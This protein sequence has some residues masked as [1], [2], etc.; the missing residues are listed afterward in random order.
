MNRSSTSPLP[1]SISDMLSNLSWFIDVSIV[2]P[3]ILRFPT[4]HKVTHVAAGR[5]FNEKDNHYTR[6]YDMATSGPRSLAPCILEATGSL[7]KFFEHAASAAVG[8]AGSQGCDVGWIAGIVYVPSG[9]RF[10][11]LM[12]GARM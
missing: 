1:I 8:G 5:R 6:N 9:N 11:L 4:A 2:Y 10:R 12:C 3:S 7:H